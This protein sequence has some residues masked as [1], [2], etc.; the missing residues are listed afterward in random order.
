MRNDFSFV[1]AS[2]SARRERPRQR[3][4]AATPHGKPAHPAAAA[5]PATAS[6]RSQTDHVRIIPL[7]GLGEVGRNMMVL[8]YAGDMIVIDV[9]FG[10][11]DEDMPGIDFLIPN[12]KYLEDKKDRIRGVLVTHGHYD[13]IGALP[14]LIEKLGNPPIWTAPLTRGMLLK[15]HEEFPR[16]PKLEIHQVK[17]GDK[18]VLGNFQVKPETRWCWAIFKWSFS[19]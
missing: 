2:A 18:V 13:H 8:E 16:L 19:M 5:F 9:G 14:Y 3:R 10:F 12:V 17:A 1:L 4:T 7:G 15:R 6:A 11:P